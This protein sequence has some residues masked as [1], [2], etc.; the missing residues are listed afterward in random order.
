MLLSLVH[1]PDVQLLNRVWLSVTPWTVAH[2]FLCPWDSP[3]QNIGVGCHAV[4]QGIFLTQGSNSVLLH[5]RL[6]LYHSGKPPNF[7][8]FKCSQ[9]VE[10]RISSVSPKVKMIG[11]AILLNDRQLLGVSFFFFSFKSAKLTYHLK[12]RL[13]WYNQNNFNTSEMILMNASSDKCKL[14]T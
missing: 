10:E 13:Y 7:Y 4:L 12:I 14:F 1:S 2:Q 11:E 8:I 5:C 9:E 6:T 3:G